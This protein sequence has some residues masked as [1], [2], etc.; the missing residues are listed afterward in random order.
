MVK[1]KADISL[2]E[3]L[4][5][6]ARPVDSTPT[7]ITEASVDQPRDTNTT[8]VEPSSASKPRQSAELAVG[9]DLLESDHT[10]VTGVEG[11]A[12]AWFWRLLEQADYERW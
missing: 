12:H 7:N 6:S 5:Q 2:D 4:S 10:Q 11:E 3:W 8:I 9:P 1:R